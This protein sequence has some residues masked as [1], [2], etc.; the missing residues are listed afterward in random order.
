MLQLMVLVECI[1]W[2]RVAGAGVECYVT[3]D[4]SGG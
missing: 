4:D 3:L 1:A 2:G